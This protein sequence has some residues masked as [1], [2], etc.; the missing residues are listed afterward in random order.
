MIE[1]ATGG[2]VWAERY[3]RE[4]KDIFA[5]QDD[6][7][8]KIV[9]A[10]EVKLTAHE[11]GRVRLTPTGNLEAYDYF[12]R[13]LTQMW[14][15]TKASNRQARQLFEQALMLDSDYA[16][17]TAFLGFNYSW[18]W[19]SWNP[20]PQVLERA[21]ELLQRAIGLDDSLPE[22]HSILGLVYAFKKQHDQAVAEGERAIAL[23][24][25]YADGYVWLGFIA[26]FTGK[27]E[28]V[29]ELLKQA[30]RLNPH[31][32][33]IYYAT[34][35]HAYYLQRRYEE[36]IAAQKKSLLLNPTN[37]GDHILIACSY[38]ELGRKQEAR[39]EI[40]EGLRLSPLASPNSLKE[41]IPYADPAVSQ[42]LFDDARKALATLGVRDYVSIV[43]DRVTQYFQE[44]RTRDN[45]LS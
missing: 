22:A 45:T 38:I 41:R 19:A 25:N 29:F 28:E 16:A 43:K 37:A 27:L 24:A 20:R 1:A 4:L 26:C 9:R 2:H 21:F 13:G 11:Q 6:V 23:N 40:R 39:A 36:A 18:E 44:R 30:Q 3:D 17:A 34:L 14:Q 15:L 35:G 33:F 7:R 42:R 10:L 32:P 31:P 12:L 8:Q 5:L